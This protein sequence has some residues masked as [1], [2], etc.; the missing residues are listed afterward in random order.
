VF[1]PPHREFL[2]TDDGT[3]SLE[4]AIA[5]L[6]AVAFGLALVAVVKGDTVLN[7]LRSILERAFAV[8]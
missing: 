2:R 3:V 4:Y 7:G 8:N 5:T 6:A 1:I